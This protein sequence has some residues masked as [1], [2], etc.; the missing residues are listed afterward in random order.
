MLAGT[1]AI[2]KS[3]P[4]RDLARVIHH[5]ISK[6]ISPHLGGGAVTTNQNITCNCP[7]I[8][9]CRED[10]LGTLRQRI[11]A[12]FEEH[13]ISIFDKWRR[14]GQREDRRDEPDDSR[15]QISRHSHVRLP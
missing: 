7:P 10:L 5:F 1:L 12:M 15:R 8:C 6:D 14:P 13:T 3:A 4:K 2:G 11:E 9:E